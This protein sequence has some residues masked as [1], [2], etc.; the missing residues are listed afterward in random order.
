MMTNKQLYMMYWI[1]DCS[2]TKEQVIN[3]VGEDKYNYYYPIYLLI[4]RLSRTAFMKK[5][6]VLE[7]KK[8]YK[9]NCSCDICKKYGFC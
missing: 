1:V 8:T 7:N 5:I 3:R 4:K 9:K 2:I 6:R